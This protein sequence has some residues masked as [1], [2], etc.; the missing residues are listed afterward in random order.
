MYSMLQVLP[1]VIKLFASSD[2]AIRVGLLQHIESFG[3]GLSTQVV[4]EQVFAHVATGFADTSA[5]LRE[6]TLKSM[7]VIAP[8]LS[9]RTLTGSLL[10]HLSKLQVDEE[11]AIRT[12]TTILLGNIASH[13]NEAVSLFMH[14]CYVSTLVRW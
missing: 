8:K 3:G 10:K 7:L 11:P 1:T 13:L 5:F 2:R 14:L 4:D 12:N 9:Q 6:L